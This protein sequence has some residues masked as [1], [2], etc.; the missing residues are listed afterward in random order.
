MSNPNNCMV[1]KKIE[2]N[3][4]N[5]YWL[6]LSKNVDNIDKKQE[7]IIRETY[8][9]LPSFWENILDN[10]ISAALHVGLHIK[11]NYVDEFIKDIQMRV[12]FNA[13]HIPYF[14]YQLNLV[15]LHIVSSTAEVVSIRALVEIRDE[16]KMFFAFCGIPQ[17]TYENILR[18]TTC[19]F[20]EK[21]IDFEIGL[22]LIRSYFAAKNIQH[23]WR[24]Y[25]KTKKAA[26][27]I[28]R[29]WKRQISSPFTII[30]KNRLRREF[31]E[32]I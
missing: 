23:H 26:Q 16:E 12:D 11:S 4:L 20:F 15:P 14:F 5:K 2:V 30:G 9:K 31:N 7:N 8:K 19:Q 10:I 3:A 6:D 25:I 28:Q 17:N 24:V 29:A 18:Y 32:M 21:N 27:T 1:E 13:S 22:A